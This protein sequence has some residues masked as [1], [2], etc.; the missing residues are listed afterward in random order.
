[1][2][3]WCF[4]EGLTMFSSLQNLFSSNKETSTTSLSPTSAHLRPEAASS[5]S[6]TLSSD[7]SLFATNPKSALGNVLDE[8]LHCSI[9]LELFEKP[10]FLECQHTLCQH[11]IS[12]LLAQQEGQKGLLCPLCRQKTTAE[13]LKKLKPDSFRERLVQGY[14][15]SKLDH[16][17]SP[18]PIKPPSPPTSPSTKDISTF[19]K[20]A[21]K[22][23]RSD[24]GGSIH[25]LR[26]VQSTIE[27][28]IDSCFETTMKDISSQ[29]QLLINETKAIIEREAG[30]QKSGSMQ[31]SPTL[32]C[33]IDPDSDQLQE[34]KRA[35]LQTLLPASIVVVEKAKP[36]N[37]SP[38]TTSVSISPQPSPSSTVSQPL[39]QLTIP[40]AF[41]SLEEPDPSDGI[42]QVDRSVPGID[43][44]TSW[45][46]AGTADA[47]GFS[48]SCPIELQGFGLFGGQGQY[49]CRIS[50]KRAY[51][52]IASTSVQFTNN[53]TSI[54]K[55]FFSNPIRL[56]P[57]TVYNAVALIAG[58]GSY[59]IRGCTTTLTVC[60]R[61]PGSTSRQ[62]A[63]FTFVDATPPTNGTNVDGGQIPVLLFK[64]V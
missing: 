48:V 39:S 9:C 38:S 12:E 34:C 6:R 60:G 49:D 13:K 63:Q 26:S 52:E 55:V 17:T 40:D 14:K 54:T 58:W 57:N 61:A 64:F 42:Y 31:A 47:I 22:L 46:Y 4:F 56:E 51:K 41:V 1:M 62:R 30:N 8:E 53:D 28:L 11:H 18:P 20:A 32:I 50:L 36:S 19:S 27:Q 15:K 7:W 43:L 24:G 37:A 5:R 45:C 44:S 59:Y 3:H 21:L 10:V 35:I 25:Q 23:V 2:V 29:R 33:S 16:E